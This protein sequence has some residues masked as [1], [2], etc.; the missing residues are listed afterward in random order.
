MSFFGGKHFCLF[1]SHSPI[2]LLSQ[3]LLF[4]KDGWSEMCW[5][6]AFFPTF[7]HGIWLERMISLPSGHLSYVASREPKLLDPY[8]PLSSHKIYPFPLCPCHTAN[9]TLMTLT[10]KAQ[11]GTAQRWKHCD[12]QPGQ[13]DMLSWQKRPAQGFLMQLMAHYSG[14]GGMDW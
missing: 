2:P 4:Q 14:L 13:G 12:R 8:A 7:Q 10:W 9:L 11:G 5:C 1:I 3:L 6:G